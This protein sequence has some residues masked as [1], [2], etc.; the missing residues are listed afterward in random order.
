M[1]TGILRATAVVALTLGITSVAP[2][3]SAHAPAH[4]APV[5]GPAGPAG[6][7]PTAVTGRP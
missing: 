5:A 6:A 4:P 2:M 1:R 7:A 3:A